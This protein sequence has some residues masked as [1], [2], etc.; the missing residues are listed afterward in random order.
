MKF[1]LP[2]QALVNKFIAKDKFYK[3][4]VVSTKLKD[5][6]VQKIRKITWLYK[7]AESTIWIKKTETVEEVQIFELQLKSREL[8]KKVIQLIDKAIPY[9]ILYVCKYQD[10]TAY[11]ITYTKDDKK[12]SYRSERDQDMKFSFEW[13]TLESMYQWLISCFIAKEDDPPLAFDTLIDT[14]TKKQE[15]EKQIQVLENKIKK[16]KQ[17]NKKVILNQELNQKKKQRDQ[18]FT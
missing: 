1:A 17:F 12:L 13:Y 11:A 2:Q 7:L 6:F 5:E 10:H 8:P 9:Q 4:A 15:L 14:N 16:E 18:L 3:H